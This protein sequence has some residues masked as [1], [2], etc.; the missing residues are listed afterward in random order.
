MARASHQGTLGAPAAMRC[1][2]CRSGRAASSPAHKPERI[3]RVSEGTNMDE[4]GGAAEHAAVPL[5]SGGA[6]ESKGMPVTPEAT[7][8]TICR[9]YA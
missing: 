4:G 2:R 3:R 1:K 5:N 8:V 7:L 9:P 6:A